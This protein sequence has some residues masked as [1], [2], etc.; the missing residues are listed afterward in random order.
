MTIDW[1]DPNET[2]QYT[3]WS[4]EFE[5]TTLPEGMFTISSCRDLQAIGYDPST[6]LTGDLEGHYVLDRDIDC[7]DSVNWVWGTNVDAPGV[8]ILLGQKVLEAYLTVK[9]TVSLTYI[10]NLVY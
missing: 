10:K 5:I 2:E 1:N 8:G 7:A 6:G 4:N 9:A 3:A